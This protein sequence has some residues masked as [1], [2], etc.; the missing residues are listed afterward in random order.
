MRGKQK[1]SSTPCRVGGNSNTIFK[2]VY[3]LLLKKYIHWKLLLKILLAFLI[4]MRIA[5]P[6]SFFLLNKSSN[7]GHDGL[8]RKKLYN[9]VLV[10]SQDNFS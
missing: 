5:K 10:M 2:S 4:L 9:T 7:Q 1:L 3:Y 8:K 6:S